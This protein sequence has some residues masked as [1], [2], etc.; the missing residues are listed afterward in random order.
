ME[1][2]SEKELK[3]TQKAALSGT[4][5]IALAF[6]VVNSGDIIEC[7]FNFHDCSFESSLGQVW[8]DSVFLGFH[9]VFSRLCIDI[10]I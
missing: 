3:R 8:I 9:C 10:D 7:I 5:N 2:I 6:N 4:L 1:N